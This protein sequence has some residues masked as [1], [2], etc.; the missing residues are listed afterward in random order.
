MHGLSD[1]FCRDFFHHVR[2]HSPFFGELWKNLPQELNSTEQVPVTDLADYW[3]AAKEDRINTN[4]F[5]ND[6]V[7]FR[8]G[9]TTSEPKVIYAT[10]DEVKQMYQNLSMALTDSSGIRPGDRIA[11]LCH[12]GGM[13]AGFLGMTLSL[14]HLQVPHVHLPMTGN[15]PVPNIAEFLSKFKA[16]VI[17]G[18]VF[19]VTRVVEYLV[20][21][22]KTVPS[23]RLILYFGEN[24]FLDNRKSW[25]RAFPNMVAHPGMYASGDGGLLGIPAELP[26]VREDSDIKPI[27]KANRPLIVLELLAEDGSAIKEAGIRGRVVITDLRKRL[28]PCVRYPAGDV[29]QW[30]DYDKGTFELLGRESIALKMGSLHLELPA[31]RQLVVKTMG[32]HFQDAFQI[33]MRRRDGKNEITF[34]FTGTNDDPEAVTRRLEKNLIDAFPRWQELL[35]IDY[36]QPLQTEWVKVEELV[37]SSNS[38]KLATVVDE[39]YLSK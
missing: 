31:L 38:G 26:G 6:G 14:D 7:V 35:D 8:T 4:P 33:V 21:K 27:Y 30:I 19:T 18:N 3:Q 12:V 1:E 23:M 20:S 16:T 37:V 5:F 22:G 17:I 39:R 24:F 36:I 9:G 34:R 2:T 29:A 15:E 10:N 28:F 25:L 32:R 13:Y 11:N